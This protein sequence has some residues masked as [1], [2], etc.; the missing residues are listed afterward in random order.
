VKIIPIDS[1]N[2]IDYS[3]AQM[4]GECKL[5]RR[6]T[7]ADGKAEA[8]RLGRLLEGDPGVSLRQGDKVGVETRKRC[9]QMIIKDANAHQLLRCRPSRPAV[10]EHLLWVEL[11]SGISG[12][13]V[14]FGLSSDKRW[15]ITWFNKHLTYFLV[16]RGMEG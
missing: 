9:F 8:W 1:I 15:L 3:I 6:P 16:T 5:K 11:S 14:K 10:F 12:T 2:W 4:R 7:Q 13:Y